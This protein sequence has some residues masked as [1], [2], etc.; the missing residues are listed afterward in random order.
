[1]QNRKQ[2]SQSHRC[3]AATPGWAMLS[4][5]RGRDGSVNRR[6]CGTTSTRSSMALSA[7]CSTLASF[8]FFFR[9]QTRW[10]LFPPHCTSG[11]RFALRGARLV[12]APLCCSLSPPP[13]SAVWAQL[14]AA[15]CGSTWPRLRR[16]HHAPHTCLALANGCTQNGIRNET[17]RTIDDAHAQHTGAHHATH[18]GACA[19]TAS[20]QPTQRTV[21]CAQRTQD[22]ILPH[23]IQHSPRP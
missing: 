21:H 13:L 4:A 16:A 15:Q 14:D 10:P 12:C 2:I 20:Q 19:Q 23:H 18:C 11:L 17:T 7:V 3:A 5:Q 1:M 8:V 9:F 6:S 22:S